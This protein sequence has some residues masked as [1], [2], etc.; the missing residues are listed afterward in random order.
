MMFNTTRTLKPEKIGS[1]AIGCAVLIVDAFA[2][3]TLKPEYAPIYIGNKW[4]KRPAPMQNYNKTI[5]IYYKKNYNG[6]YISGV[7]AF[8]ENI[9]KLADFGGGRDRMVR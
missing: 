6:C 7:S 1:S 8:D 2:Q 4:Y 3:P 9:A 5:A